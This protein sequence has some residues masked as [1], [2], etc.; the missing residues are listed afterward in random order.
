M[1]H[2]CV[3][4][5]PGSE[6]EIVGLF[7]VR[8]KDIY[9]YKK[10]QSILAN[11]SEYGNAHMIPPSLASFLFGKT[12]HN[13]TINYKLVFDFSGFVTHFNNFIYIALYL[14]LTD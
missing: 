3:Q 2:W 5:Q 8:M 9:Y 4:V 14:W 11:N 10:K 6:Y 12:T 1:K 13:R 7:P